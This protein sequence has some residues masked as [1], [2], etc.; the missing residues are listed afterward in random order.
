[1]DIQTVKEF[2]EHQSVDDLQNTICFAQQRIQEIREKQQD[3]YMGAIRKAFEDYF[4]NVGPIE[5]TF[6]YEDID[7][8]EGTTSVEVDSINPPCFRP[9]A[10]EFP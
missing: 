2:L 5:V 6:I 1:M 9:Q 10:I 4:E 7:G 8:T 3:K